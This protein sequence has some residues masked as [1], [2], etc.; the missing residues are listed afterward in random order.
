MYDA[1][2]AATVDRDELNVHV[3]VVAYIN[4]VLSGMVLL[5]AFIAF[6]FFA[7]LAEDAPGGGQNILIF[8]G[9]FAL[10]ACGAIAVPGL[11]AGFGLLYRQP[12]A[13]AL[14]MCVAVLDLL[15]FPVGTAIGAYSLWVLTKPEWFSATH[16]SKY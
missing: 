4:I 11:A 6:G 14:A 3:T 9:T 16:E 7:F 15:L 10:V 2:G 13:R 5:A 1:M 8:L 12:W